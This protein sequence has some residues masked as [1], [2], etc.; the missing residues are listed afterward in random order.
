MAC[1]VCFEEKSLV[2]LTCQH[3]FCAECLHEWNTTCPLC[4]KPIKLGLTKY[5]KLYIGLYFSVLI[6]N[7]VL[8]VL[9]RAEA[10]QITGILA[11][12]AIVLE[13]CDL[14]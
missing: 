3:S 5:Q 9:T 14:L 10:Y 11:V 13:Q 1:P 8:L 4:R 2:R 6:V 12:I 7:I